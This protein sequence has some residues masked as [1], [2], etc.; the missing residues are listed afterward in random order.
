MNWD[1]RSLFSIL[2]PISRIYV[3]S[4]LLSAIWMIAIPLWVSYWLRRQRARGIQSVEIIHGRLARLEGHL[5]Q[6]F[7]L[8]V[9]SFCACLSNQILQG[10]RLEEA[11]TVNPNIDVVPPFDGLSAISQ[12]GFVGLGLIHSV[13]WFVS[14][15]AMQYRDK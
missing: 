8:N 5:R 7:T 6:F 10:I 9:I 1:I 2:D 13:R 11:I 14:A 12:F 4:L 3:F 15:K